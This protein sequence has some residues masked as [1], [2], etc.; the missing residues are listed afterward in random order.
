MTSDK[1]EKLMRLDNLVLSKMTDILESGKTEQLGDLSTVVNYLKAN[2]QVEEKKSLSQNDKQKEL[3]E[4]YNKR[5]M[6]RADT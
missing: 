6:E 2:Q 3:I 1:R 5:R 4:K